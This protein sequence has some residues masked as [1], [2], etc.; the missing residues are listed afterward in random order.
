MKKTIKIG[1]GLLILGAILIIFGI[2]NNGIQSVYWHNGFHVL[3][4]TTRTYHPKTI[5]TITLATA[6]NVIIRRGDTTKIQVTASH[7]RPTI[8]TDHG[9]VTIKSTAANTTGFLLHSAT[10]VTVITLPQTAK[11]T[12]VTATANQVG[13]LRLHHLNIDRLKLSGQG[14]VNLSQVT[15]TQPLTL[16]TTDDVQ[17]TK[18]QAPSLTIGAEA[19][20]IHITQSQFTKAASN[21][22]TTDGDITVHQTTFKSGHISSDEGDIALRDN[23]LQQRLT[24]NATDGDI[25]V[26]APHQVG[27]N[28]TTSEG[29]LSIFDWKNDDQNHYQVHTDATSQYDL[30]TTEGDI[31]VTAA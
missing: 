30:T 21:L 1:F 27:I 11:L 19:D 31:T 28:A 12:T 18:V 8:T 2:A 24:V 9:H 13:N 25:T 3:K 10:D 5:K 15:V 26:R 6:N 17:L 22:K 7:H 14:A 20:D 4:Q 16:A 29:D 23:H